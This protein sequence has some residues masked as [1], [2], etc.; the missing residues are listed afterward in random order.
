MARRRPQG[1]E[2]A[3]ELMTEHDGPRRPGAGAGPSANKRSFC[4][5]SVTSALSM[6]VDLATELAHMGH[7]VTSF[8]W[9]DIGD[10]LAEAPPTRTIAFSLS[11]KA[12]TAAERAGGVVDVAIFDQ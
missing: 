10:K 5:S 9:S 3:P 6:L 4:C 7:S 2:L 8:H 11:S 12:M 1:C